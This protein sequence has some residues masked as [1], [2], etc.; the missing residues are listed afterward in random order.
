MVSEEFDNVW[1][2]PVPGVLVFD[3]LNST[4]SLNTANSEARSV[5]EAADDA[6]LPL[7]GADDSLVNLGWLV[8]VDH[9]DVSLCGRNDKQLVLDVHTVHAVL[10]GQC[11]DWLRAL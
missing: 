11:A 5:G 3:V 2:I 9:V 8:Q 6:R 4:A 1:R 10:A 7:E